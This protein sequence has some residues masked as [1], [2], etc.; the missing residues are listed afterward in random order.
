MASWPPAN[1]QPIDW[2]AYRLSIASLADQE[3]AAAAKAEQEAATSTR[4]RTTKPEPVNG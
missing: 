4:K 1:P 2:D 3:A